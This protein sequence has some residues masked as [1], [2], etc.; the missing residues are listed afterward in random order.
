DL[1]LIYSEERLE[2]RVRFETPTHLADRRAPADRP[3][4]PEIPAD[5]DAYLFFT[6]GSTGRPKGV[7]LTHAGYHWAVMQFGFLHDVLQGGAAL[8]AAPLFHMNAQFH[9]KSI[10]SVGGTAILTPHFEARSFLTAAERHEAVR[11]TG[12]PTMFE[13]AV[14]ELESGFQADLSNV[15]S[16]A[17]GSAPVSIGLIDRLQR[18]FSNAVITNGYGTTEIGPATFGPHPAGKPAPPLSLG[19]PMPGVRVRLDGPRAPHEGVLKVKTKMLTPGYLNLPEETAKKFDQGWY[20]T[21][22]KMRRD[23]D[24]FYFFVG[25]ADDMFVCGGENIYPG[26]VEKRLETHPAIHQAAVVPVEDDIKGALPVAFLVVAADAALTVDEVKQYALERGP[27]YA[28]PRFVYFETELPLS[29]VNKVDK[30]T[31]VDWA[32]SR[33]ADGARAG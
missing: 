31:L 2:G 4:P 11:L 6:S 27:A 20:D 16:I 15:R 21:G 14:R 1:T 10:L 8:V 23:D 33:R 29:G 12:V 24:G 18:R 3:A 7:P 19:F 9:I 22:D 13:L 26:E 5:A 32:H 17:L 30:V 28:H 25:R